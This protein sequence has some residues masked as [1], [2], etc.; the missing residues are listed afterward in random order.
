MTTRDRMYVAACMLPPSKNRDTI[1]D[2]IVLEARQRAQP[3]S[4]LERQAVRYYR[5]L[6][7]TVA[8]GELPAT[9]VD[10]AHDW[11]PQRMAENAVRFFVDTNRAG[12][13]TAVRRAPRP[14]KA[15]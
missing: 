12:R 10:R 15:A 7:N 11:I 4:E 2:G 14:P 9:Y 8:A 6:L 5:K 13:T 3:K 1:I